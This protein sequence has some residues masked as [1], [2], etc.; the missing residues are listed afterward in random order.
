MAKFCNKERRLCKKIGQR[1]KIVRQLRQLTQQEVGT[2]IGI[3]SQQVAKYE[4][5]QNRIAATRLVYLAEVLEVD[6]VHLI[7]SDHIQSLG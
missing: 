2:A 6:F 7:P 1:L 4:S 5:G 3:S